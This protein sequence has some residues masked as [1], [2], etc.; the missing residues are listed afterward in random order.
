MP[1]H[2]MPRHAMPRHAI[3]LTA[4]LLAA[5][6]GAAVAQNVP[7]RVRGTIEASDGSTLTVKPR[8]AADLK[9]HLAP[10][11]KIVAARKASLADIKPGAYVGIANTG[12]DGSQ[13]ALEVHI[14]PEAMRGTGDG[15][16]AWDLGKGSRMTNG[17]VDKKVA[18]YDGQNLTLTYK[19]GSSTI[20]VRPNTPVVAFTAGTAADLK[21]GAAVFVRETKREPDG[22]VEAATIVVGA[23][24]L[25]PPM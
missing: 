9:L 1:K 19:G 11:A 23:D 3:F 24:G 5:L 10:G 16:R 7:L 2:A 14:F 22:S 13:D 12:T 21:T 25:T 8:N 15:Q 20:Q 18:A 4:A 6:D 17:A